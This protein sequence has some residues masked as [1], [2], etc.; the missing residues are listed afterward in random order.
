MKVFFSKAF[1]S[2]GIAVL[3][4]SALV[5]CA[6]ADKPDQKQDA[7]AVESSQVSTPEPAVKPAVASESKV[8]EVVA[9]P[10]PESE[11]L[12][13]VSPAELLS[14]LKAVRPE[15]PVEQAVVQPSKIAGLYEVTLGRE[16]IYVTPDGGFLLVGDLYQIE[17]NQLV[18]LQE[19][20]R[21]EAEARFAPKR[22]E[23]LAAVNEKD[24]VIFPAIGEKK[25][26]VFV[27][28]DIDCGYCRRLHGQIEQ[29]QS[30]GIE[31]RYLAFPR[32]GA[33][34]MSAKKLETTWCSANRQE[35]M[36]RFKKGENVSLIS[37]ENPVA[38]QYELGMQVGVSGTPAIVF[39]DGTLVP[40]AVSPEQLA[41]MLKI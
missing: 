29:F 7:K 20:A 26:H 28:T 37:C 16:V 11:S 9:S 21:R 5:S 18:N 4:V 32:A 36:T 38:A 10:E 22:A 34:S 27:F 17:N 12:K 30:K 25:A 15:I 19:Q 41:S 23:L 3:S 33:Q 31:V 8:E 14:K 35:A 40:G 39:E 24:M 2:F 6:D 1:A 13:P